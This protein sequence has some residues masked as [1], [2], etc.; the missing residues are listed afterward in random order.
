MPPHPIYTYSMSR[1]RF[2]I[3]SRA[4]SFGFTR[5]AAYNWIRLSAPSYVRFETFGRVLWLAY[6]VSAVLLRSVFVPTILSRSHKSYLMEKGSVYRS[7]LETRYLL[8]S[9]QKMLFKGR[10]NFSNMNCS[11]CLDCLSAGI[12]S[13]CIVKSLKTR[14]VSEAALY[15]K[16][17]ILLME[18]WTVCF[19]L[20]GCSLNFHLFE[21][22][23]RFICC[24]CVNII[25]SWPRVNTENRYE[26]NMLHRSHF[27]SL[28]LVC[29]LVVRLF[30][31]IFP[32]LITLDL[33]YSFMNVVNELW[34]CSPFVHANICVSS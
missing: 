20:L 23:T 12:R 33:L 9:R 7:L 5:S 28:R 14:A 2:C 4:H 32:S 13:S 1:H 24:G 10:N 27:L 25:Y 17:E 8:A 19:N 18:L 3:S 34:T 22:D 21:N 15:W 29:R 26:R 11:Y 16:C 6:C 31:P 30:A